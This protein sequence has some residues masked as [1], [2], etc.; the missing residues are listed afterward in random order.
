[1]QQTENTVWTWAFCISIYSHTY[2][3][4]LLA[5]YSMHILPTIYIC[6]SPD[7]QYCHKAFKYGF[8][9]SQL[10]KQCTTLLSSATIVC[11]MGCKWLHSIC[12]TYTHVALIKLLF[13]SNINQLRKSNDFQEMCCKFQLPLA[14][15][16]FCVLISVHLICC[17]CKL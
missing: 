16:Y 5:P 4:V 17:N 13:F 2:I 8:V 14:L 1:M 10:Y 12:I 15:T 7:E 11:V 3:Q 6:I 9:L